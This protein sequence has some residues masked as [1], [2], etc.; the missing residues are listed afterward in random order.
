MSFQIACHFCGYICQSELPIVKKDGL[1]QLECP[2]CKFIL[3]NLYG[4]ESKFTKMMQEYNN[5]SK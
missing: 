4:P 1:L 2:E 3:F 5:D